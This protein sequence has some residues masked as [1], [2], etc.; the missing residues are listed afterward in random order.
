MG[1]LRNTVDAVETQLTGL[2]YTRSKLNFTLEHVPRSVAHR[3]YTFGRAIITPAYLAGNTSDYAHLGPFQIPLLILWKARGSHNTAATFQEAYLDAL[4][5]YEAIEVELV[6]N[7]SQAYQEN[8]LIQSAE[9]TPLISDDQDLLLI[10][11]VL[12]IDVVR[13]L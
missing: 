4:D 8:N 7:Q 2:S 11:I 12:N 6:K 13:K 1:T 3:S 5:A 10:N 9:I